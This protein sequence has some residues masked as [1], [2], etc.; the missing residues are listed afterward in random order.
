[1]QNIKFLLLGFIAA[2]G[3]LAVEMILT[4]LFPGEAAL[5]FTQITFLLIL[6]V[7][8][9]ELFK[10]AVMLKSV[11]TT[12]FFR[13]SFLISAGFALTEIFLA[14]SKNTGIIQNNLYPLLA[15][16]GIIHLT[17]GIICGYS[18]F[19]YKKTGRALTPLLLL[20]LAIVLHLI[21]NVVIIK[22]I[23]N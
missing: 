3:A 17:T 5:V 2:L 11:S 4:M 8:T 10:F 18:A 6:L 15:G 9:E 22:L 12:S 20:I 14:Y 21:Y 1:M 13:P 19:A 7:A 16:V 23:R